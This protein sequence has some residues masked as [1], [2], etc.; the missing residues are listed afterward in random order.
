MDRRDGLLVTQSPEPERRSGTPLGG[1]KAR[2]VQAEASSSL[3]I[4]RH[5]R[6]PPATPSTSPRLPQKEEDPNQKATANIPT[7]AMQTG[8]T[9][10]GK[11]HT[12]IPVPSFPN[13]PTAAI[14]QQKSSRGIDKSLKDSR[15]SFQQNPATQVYAGVMQGSSDPLGENPQRP[16]TKQEENKLE[17][18][19]MRR[20]RRKKEEEALAKQTKAS[21]W[22]HSKAAKTEGANSPKD[23]TKEPITKEDFYKRKEATKAANAKFN[24]QKE[25]RRRSEPRREETS[26]ME[27]QKMEPKGRSFA[28]MSLG[29]QSMFPGSNQA[30]LPD[31]PTYHQPAGRHHGTHTEGALRIHQKLRGERQLRTT[32]GTRKTPR[33]EL[34]GRRTVTDPSRPDLYPPISSPPLPL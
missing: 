2:L 3:S 29:G 9:P 16:L 4:P 10:Q 17:G 25:E 20:N 26:R 15:E 12:H 32:T 5:Y 13:F 23:K 27:P 34:G 11:R 19:K 30:H 6:A 7:A 18:D 22:E 31:T 8:A 33:E 14:L 21:T 24:A 1:N 28:H